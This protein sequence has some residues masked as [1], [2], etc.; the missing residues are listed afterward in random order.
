MRFSFEH[1]SV[2]KEDRESLSNIIA[3]Y[4]SRLETIISSRAYEEPESSICLPSDDSILSVVSSVY[5]EKVKRPLKYV[6]V[7]GIGGSNLGAKAVYDALIGYKDAVKDDNRPQIIFFDTNDEKIIKANTEHILKNTIDAQEILIVIISKSG[8]TIETAANADY[9]I[10]ELKNKISNIE[11]RTITITDENS[12]LWQ[13]AIKR[14]IAKLAIPKP[15]GGRYSVFSAVGLLPL[16]AAG[17]DVLEFRKGALQVSK[18]CFSRE[19]A[20]NPAVSGAIF[21]GYWRKQNKSI[22]DIFFFNPELESLGKWYRQLLGESIGKSEEAGITPTVSIGTTD[23]HSMGQLYLRGPRDKTTLF[24]SSAEQGK[25]FGE[26][27]KAALS[28]TE[29]VYEKHNSPF[30]EAIFDGITASELG[31]FMQWKMIETMYLAKILSVNAFD[32]PD[33]ESYKKET[34]KILEKL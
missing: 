1:D 3:P 19:L 2:P 16:M 29:I 24:V 6:V 27:M 23:L 12:P 28:G 13:S 18:L 17:I 31:A 10:R 21:L 26:I 33:V 4:M 32:Q 14:G 20:K 34:A 7:V 25:S 9:L 15:I 30:A 22:H 11:E 5:K 8:T